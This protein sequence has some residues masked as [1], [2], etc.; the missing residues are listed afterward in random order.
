[1][2]TRGSYMYMYITLNYG[3]IFGGVPK[4]LVLCHFLIDGF[5]QNDSQGF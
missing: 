3:N 5:R 1:M 2:A 4:M